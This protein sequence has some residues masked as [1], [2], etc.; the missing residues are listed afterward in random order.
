MNYPKANLLSEIIDEHFYNFPE[1]VALANGVKQFTFREL[2]VL[3][4]NVAHDLLVKG[5]QKGDRVC[6]IAR[7]HIEIIPF[8][9]GIWKAGAI[10]SPLDPEL[11]LDR[12][13]KICGNI[14]PKAIVGSGD[15]LSRIESID[16]PIKLNFDSC[17]REKEKDPDVIFP[18]LNQEDDAIII[19]TSGTTGLPKGVVLSHRS[20]IAYFNSHRF[21]LGISDASR[22]LNTSSFHYDVSIQDTFQPLFFGAYV[23]LANHFFI[24]ELVLP[25]MINQKFTL[26]TAVSTVLSLITGDISNLDKYK[27]P[28]L[29]C[30]STGAEVCSIK[31]INKWIETNPLVCVV[32]GYGPS[33]VNSVTVSYEIN[34]DNL[35]PQRSE[36]Y[37]IGKPHIGVKAILVDKDNQVVSTINEDGELYLGGK[38]LMTRYWG[39]ENSTANAFEIID[40]E[41][42]YKTGD[43]CSYDSEYNLVYNYRKDLEVKY[44]GRRIN[45]AE[46]TGII[47]NNFNFQGVECCLLRL[48]DADSYLCLII[49]VEDYDELTALKENVRNV[50]IEKLPIHSVPNVFGFYNQTIQTSSGKVDRKSLIESYRSAFE[51]Y[52]SDVMIYENGK[53][54]PIKKNIS[55][56]KQNQYD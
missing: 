17:Y 2:F 41:K 36:Y 35:D 25:L 6:I 53:F 9:I 7:K 23:Y 31:L 4:E 44:N 1:K 34:Y 24:P 38:Q 21:I 14:S 20:V 45:L 47:Q 18:S 28:D 30:I 42:Y 48:N 43:I 50:L 29:R 51:A 55:N 32:N 46:I 27:F 13:G 10:Y 26:V 8:A 39:D 3:A 5:V 52:N 54:N 22:C 33:E 19:H 16:I 37:P 40:N 12:L 15:D 56:P 49:R 11:P